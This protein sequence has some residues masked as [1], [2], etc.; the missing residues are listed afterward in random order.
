ML[1]PYGAAQAQG[2]FV[3]SVCV[4]IDAKDWGLRRA[5]LLITRILGVTP[6]GA[7]LGIMKC[8]QGPVRLPKILVLIIHAP[9]WAGI[10]LPPL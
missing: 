7:R 3:E 4:I 2:R 8:K 5:G 9:R 1:R 6:C 10:L